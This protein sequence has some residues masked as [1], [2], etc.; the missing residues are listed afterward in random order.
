MDRISTAFAIIVHDFRD[1]GIVV[2]F[3][4]IGGKAAP[5]RRL[6]GKEFRIDQGKV[7]LWARFASK[8]FVETR[9]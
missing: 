7:R 4:A 2:E 1:E 6:P 3:R 8:V 5:E 9:Q